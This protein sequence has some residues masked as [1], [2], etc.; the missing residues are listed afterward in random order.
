MP[1]TRGSYVAILSIPGSS[2][3]IRKELSTKLLFDYQ[4]IAAWEGATLKSRILGQQ[5][6]RQ[7]SPFKCLDSNFYPDF[8]TLRTP[9]T[10]DLLKP[11]TNTL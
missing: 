7:V 4:V 8:S 3:S 9:I 5:E 10:Y 11:R 1:S 6:F 2:K